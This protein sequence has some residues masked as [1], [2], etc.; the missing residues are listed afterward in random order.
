MRHVLIT[1]NC[2]R[3]AIAKQLAYWFPMWSITVQEAPTSNPNEVL[4]ASLSAALQNTSLWLAIDGA[5]WVKDMHSSL[6]TGAMVLRI[7]S[8]GFSA[9]H[10]DVCFVTT[11]SLHPRSD[12]PFHSA[13]AAWG[14]QHQLDP[15]Q[16][17]GL[18][19]SDNYAALG[20][21]SQWHESVAYLEKQ[22]QQS[23]LALYFEPFFLAIKRQG[24]FMHTFNHPKPAVITSLCQYI[25]QYLGIA[26]ERSAVLSEDDC[27]T[28]A[29]DWPLYP[30]VAMM[31]GATPETYGWRY[32]QRWVPDLMSFVAEQFALY[33]QWQITPKD[34]KPMHRDTALLDRVLGMPVGLSG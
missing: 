6:T 21:F 7:P 16:T 30:E 28:S 12:P 5:S 10:P 22:F 2:Q 25:C 11:D 23:D 8:I 26:V 34:L 4:K 27:T 17:C 1:G 24:R 14:Y 13:I 9:F 29:L 31:L 15:A 3:Y 18:Y 32:G 20:Y 33:D 19:R